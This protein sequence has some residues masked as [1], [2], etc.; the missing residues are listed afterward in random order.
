MI[1]LGMRP[2]NVYELLFRYHEL[3]INIV[4]RAIDPSKDI[5]IENENIH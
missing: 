2:L 4:V 1:R 3:L 5:P